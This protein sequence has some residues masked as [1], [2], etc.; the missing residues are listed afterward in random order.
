MPDDGSPAV[1]MIPC[2]ANP[3]FYRTV[4][5]VAGGVAA[6]ARC[7]VVHLQSLRRLV[8]RDGGLL[9]VAALVGEVLDDLRDDRSRGVGLR[10]ASCD[11]DVGRRAFDKDAWDRN[12]GCLFITGGSAAVGLIKL[13]EAMERGE[14]AGRHPRR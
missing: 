5:A 10:A 14:R 8:G 6:D 2:R 7:A 9:H 11:R 13:K 1:C 3:L 4:A 12:Y